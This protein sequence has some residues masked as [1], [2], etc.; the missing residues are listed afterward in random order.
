MYQQSVSTS[1]FTDLLDLRGDDGE[2]CLHVPVQ[3]VGH[4]HAVSHHVDHDVVDAGEKLGLDKHH[5][6]KFTHSKP[7]VDLIVRNPY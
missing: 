2:V 5:D 6:K 4:H 1:S 7:N 3:E